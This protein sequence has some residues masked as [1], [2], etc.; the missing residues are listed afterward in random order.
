MK[1]DC[2]GQA[3][4]RVPGS[5]C[6]MPDC[7]TEGPMSVT[8]RGAQKCTRRWN[9]ATTCCVTS[10]AAHG[11]VEKCWRSSTRNGS[12]EDPFHQQRRFKVRT[13]CHVATVMSSNQLITSNKGQNHTPAMGSATFRGQRSIRRENARFKIGWFRRRPAA[14][15][16]LLAGVDVKSVRPLRL[17]MIAP[18]LKAT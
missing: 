5:I 8:P 7:G 17:D 2:K 11:D 15:C 9:F 6:I 13:C 1:K 3:E 4:F 16:C 12:F 10:N 18:L 14:Q